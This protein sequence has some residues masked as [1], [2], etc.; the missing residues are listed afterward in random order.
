MQTATISA[1]AMVTRFVTLGAP[2][3]FARVGAADAILWEVPGWVA[4]LGQVLAMGVDVAVVFDEFAR[5]SP[6]PAR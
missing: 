3:A 2:T 1:F 5:P 6:R 4:E